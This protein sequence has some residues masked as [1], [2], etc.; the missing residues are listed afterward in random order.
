[1]RRIRAAAFSALPLIAAC[2]GSP[3]PSDASTAALDRPAVASLL[4][5]DADGGR[6][7]L[8][9]LPDLAPLDWRAEDRL[10]KPR[11]L[12]GATAAPPQF[13]LLDR[14]GQLTAMRLEAGRTRTVVDGAATAALSPDG[15]LYSVDTSGAAFS[16]G[17]RTPERYRARFADV[18]DQLWAGAG[19]WLVGLDSSAPAVEAFGPGDTLAIR[20]IESGTV[21]VAPW[22]DLVA[23]AADSAVWLHDPQSG[24]DPVRIKAGPGAVGAAFSPSGH[25]LYVVTTEARF[26]IIDRFAAKLRNRI[27]L[28]GPATDVRVGPEGRWVLVRPAT[29]DSIWIVDLAHDSVAG[30]VAGDWQ[31]DLPLV[32]ASNTLVL[33]AGANVIAHQLGAPGLPETGRIADAASDRWIAV[34][35]S[36]VEEER[37]AI[38]TSADSALTATGD[39][40]PG[41]TVYLQVSSSRNPEWAAELVQKLGA[42]GLHASV[43][44]PAADTEAYRVVLGP[45][46]SR[47]SAEATGRTLGMPYFIISLP[48][49]PD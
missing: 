25:Q 9:H 18:P 3:R 43:L 28:P 11:S 15:T 40:V 45:Y 37:T 6:P 29:G 14:T 47:D 2:G 49:K 4:R 21:A 24:R 48:A 26:A 30:T 1:V 34:P 23:V 44:R 12:V 17:R 36:P 10:G 35:W 13:I 31:D 32:T 42:A 33:R 16:V 8:Y 41:A 20:P 46:P 39:S 27:T 38:A 5:V 19:G 7:T 22:A